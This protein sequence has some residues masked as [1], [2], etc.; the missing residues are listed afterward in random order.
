M[1]MKGKSF[2]GRGSCHCKVLRQEHARTVERNK[3][4][5]VAT[6]KKVGG[7]VVEDEVP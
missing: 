4:A 7:R 5:W 2:P 6:V 1:T 3:E